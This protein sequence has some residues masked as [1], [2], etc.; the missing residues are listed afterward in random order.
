MKRSTE[1]SERV[2]AKEHI[3]VNGERRTVNGER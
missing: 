1:R 2:G 3:P